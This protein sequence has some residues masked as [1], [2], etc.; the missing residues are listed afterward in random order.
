MKCPTCQQTI[1]VVYVYIR[2]G[3]PTPGSE[4]PW[5]SP[6]WM[7]RFRRNI[8]ILGLEPPKRCQ[9]CFQLV[10]EVA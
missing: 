2:E 3:Y 4:H 1:P 7:D 9:T 5:Y 8:L 10:K 6:V